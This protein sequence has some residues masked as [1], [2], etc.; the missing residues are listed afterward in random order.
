[1]ISD[2]PTCALHRAR[3][4]LRSAE[5]FFRINY[6]SS[7]TIPDAGRRRRLLKARQYLAAPSADDAKSAFGSCL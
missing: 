7:C 6:A 1:M 4:R 3:S 2:S 5:P